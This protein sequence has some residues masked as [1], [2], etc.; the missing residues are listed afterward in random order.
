MILM[1]KLGH[2]NRRFIGD[3]SHTSCIPRSFGTYDCTIFSISTPSISAD[4]IWKVEWFIVLNM[5]SKLLISMCGLF[6]AELHSFPCDGMQIHSMNECQVPCV[7]LSILLQKQLYT[8]LSVQ[9][10]ILR[11]EF[12]NSLSQGK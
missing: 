8:V 12:T 10:T 7:L 5:L 1:R 6:T 4:E 3:Y 9:F 2:L 11:R